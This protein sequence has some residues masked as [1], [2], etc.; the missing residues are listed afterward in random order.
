MYRTDANCPTVISAAQAYGVTKQRS[1][2]V[3]KVGDK[4]EQTAVGLGEQ[5]T[6]LCLL[7]RQQQA[8]AACTLS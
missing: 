1:F 7:L 2:V 4:V 5:R 6:P 3:V 8:V